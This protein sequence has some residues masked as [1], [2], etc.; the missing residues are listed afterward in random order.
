[1]IKAVTTKGDII[2]GLSNENIRRLKKGE[3]ITFNLQELI[4]S[5]RNVIIFHGKTEKEMLKTMKPA[6]KEATKIHEE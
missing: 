5:D 6:I 4:G 3:P 1:M 2:L